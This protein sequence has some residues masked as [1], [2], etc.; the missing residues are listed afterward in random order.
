M[1]GMVI[2]LGRVQHPAK[3]SFSS[4]GFVS[5]NP[6]LTSATSVL[7][8]TDQSRFLKLLSDPARFHEAPNATVVTKS[9]SLRS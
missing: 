8:D 3:L 6:A 7:L 2:D 4:N 5:V 1:G 9:L